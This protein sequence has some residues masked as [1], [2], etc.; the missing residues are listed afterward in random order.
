VDKKVTWVIFD[1]EEEHYSNLM[2]QED[3]GKRWAF[4]QAR[5]PAQGEEA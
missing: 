4:V 5:E 3:Y 1:G 2:Q